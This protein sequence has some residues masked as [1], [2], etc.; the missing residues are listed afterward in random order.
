MCQKIWLTNCRE[1]STCIFYGWFSFWAGVLGEGFWLTF[2]DV[3]L[4]SSTICVLN[5]NCVVCEGMSKGQPLVCFDKIYCVLMIHSGP[6]AIFKTLSKVLFSS[7]LGLRPVVLFVYC[8]NFSNITFKLLKRCLL[9]DCH[10]RSYWVR[11]CVYVT[12]H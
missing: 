2:F 5:V 3:S 6:H 11:Q 10:R 9:E 12:W 7:S 8:H 4:Q 1:I